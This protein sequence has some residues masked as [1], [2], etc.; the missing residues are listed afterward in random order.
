MKLICRFALLATALCVFAG[1]GPSNP[2]QKKISAGSEHDYVI[3]R[4][5]AGDDLTPDQG[6][7]LDDAVSELKLKAMAHDI[8][9]TDAVTASAL[10][11]IDGKTVQE[12]IE[13][14]FAWR[15]GRLNE[16]KKFYETALA[17]N[18]QLKTAP[19]DTKSADFL[20]DRRE[21]QERQRDEA[22]SQID[23][24]K[25]ELN[26][27]N[28]PIPTPTAMPPINPDG[29]FG[30]TPGNAT[31]PSTSATGSGSATAATH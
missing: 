3:W 26:N 17:T 27:I 11:E 25:Q 1:C 7:A 29:T 28:V 20:A 13:A 23:D 30:P 31:T 19:G 6:K 18:A 16:Q 2:L 5:R 21:S 10:K 22:Q 15:L 4:Q 24:A 9:G 14:G 12:A 8:H